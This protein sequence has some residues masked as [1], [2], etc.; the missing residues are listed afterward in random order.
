MTRQQSQ[1]NLYGFDSNQ[2]EDQMPY[3]PQYMNAQ[4]VEYANFT[5]QTSAYTAKSGDF[6]LAN[7]T[8]AAFTVTLPAVALGGPVTVKKTDSASH[9]VTI[10]TADGSTIDGLTGA[11]GIGLAAQYDTVELASDGTNW[12]VVSGGPATASV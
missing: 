2:S 3:Y 9:T 4:L 6:V 10:V 12:W 1:S 8:S 7:A 11:T 5:V